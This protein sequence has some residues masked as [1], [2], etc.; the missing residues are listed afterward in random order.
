M[1]S[2]SAQTV[3]SD[4]GW[5]NIV[6]GGLSL[7]KKLLRGGA[8]KCSPPGALIVPLG[9]A[10]RQGTETTHL[11]ELSTTCCMG[12]ETEPQGQNVYAGEVT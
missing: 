12:G 4:R 11:G 10:G 6:A 5:K 8:L 2:G 1:K 3:D 9:A 7:T